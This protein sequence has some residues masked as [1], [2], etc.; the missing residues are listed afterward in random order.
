MLGVRV[1]IAGGGLVGLTLARLLRRRG[2]AP[3]VLERM[4]PGGYVKRGFMLGHQGYGALD[5]LGLLEEVLGRGRPFGATPRGPVGLGRVASCV[6]A[7][8]LQRSS[9]IA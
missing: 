6:T 1:L 8:R 2:I 5:D 9:N 7:A 3:V 4:A